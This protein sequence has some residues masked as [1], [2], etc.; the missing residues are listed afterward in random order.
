MMNGMMNGTVM[1]SMGWGGMV[2]CL[3]FALL[4]LAMLVLTVI[5]LLKYLRKSE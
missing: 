5:A 1:Q 4:F 3:L 2:V